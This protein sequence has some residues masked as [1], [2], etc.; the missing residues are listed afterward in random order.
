MEFNFKFYRSKYFFFLQIHKISIII[1]NLINNKPIS[2]Q[3]IK[4]TE[5]TTSFLHD[6]NSY[7]VLYNFNLHYINFLIMRKYLSKIFLI[8]N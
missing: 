4:Y 6:F 7:I 3:F 5:S 8:F 2:N 1:S